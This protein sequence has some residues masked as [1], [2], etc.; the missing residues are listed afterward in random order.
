MPKPPTPV[1]PAGK[2]TATISAPSIGGIAVGGD[3]VWVANQGPR[4]V[5]RID[6]QTDAVVATIPL[7]EP[8]GLVGPTNLTFGH[9]SLWV[10]DAVSSS[11]LRIDPQTNGVTASIS[12]GSPTQGNT[13][14]LGIVATPDAVWVAN[15]WGTEDALD[16]SVVRIDPRTNRIVARLGLGASPE[17]GG[18]TMLAAGSDAVWVGVPSAKSVV[19]IDAAT[20]SVVA[21]IP[22]F[23]CAD[24]QLAVDESSVLV[25]DCSSVR[26]VDTR[27]N[28][29][30]NEIAIPGDTG[31][32]V[33]GIAL[34]FG[35]IWVQA[36]RLVR[37][38][39]ASSAVTGTLPLADTWIRCG[40]SIA[41][42][43]GSVW[44]RQLDGVVRIEP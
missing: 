16:G 5:T 7:G 26:R 2:V 34:G 43:F 8:D 29:I 44:V 9:G 23:T 13:A 27:T 33:H 37:I 1:A 25:A 24:G 35:S 36:D 10:L 39:P 11:V 40:Y 41:F 22:G 21:T 18:P 28:A 6:P 3:A 31:F 32:G 42:G 30:V 38:D 17:S 12:L 20:D 14:P 4:T 15:R 19:R